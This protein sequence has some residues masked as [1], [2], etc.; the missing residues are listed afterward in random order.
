MM[1]KANLTTTRVWAMV[2]A[3]TF[4]A[5]LLIVIAATKPAHAATTFI[6][7]STGDDGDQTPEMASVSRARS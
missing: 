6:V 7:N 4:A 5:A 2:A 1:A 3:A